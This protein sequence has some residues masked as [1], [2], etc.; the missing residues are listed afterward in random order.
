MRLHKYLNEAKGDV[1]P[2]T[3]KFKFHWDNPMGSWLEHERK[4]AKKGRWGS[5]TAAF[6]DFMQIPTKMVANL[7]GKQGENRKLSDPDVIQLKASIEKY[8]LHSPVFI[9]VEYDGHAE[10]NEGN[11]RTLIAKT[12]G[13]KYI[14]VEI[15]YYAGGELIDGQWHPDRIAKIAKPWSKPKTKLP[16]P[17]RVVKQKPKPEP[18]KKTK[19]YG[20]VSRCR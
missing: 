1:I 6:G 20:L 5:T 18:K 19:R 13:W 3:K 10:I 14:P 12:L 4:G 2:K 16:V 15:R 9:N 11:R 7:K 17:K 8:G